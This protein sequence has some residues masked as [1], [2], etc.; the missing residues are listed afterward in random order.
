M[1]CSPHPGYVA[2]RGSGEA[3]RRL[4]AYPNERFSQVVGLPDPPTPAPNRGSSR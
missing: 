4:L 2:V 1:P 3:C